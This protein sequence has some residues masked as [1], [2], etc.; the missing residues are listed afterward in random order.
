[1]PSPEL[2]DM[3]LAF[4][5]HLRDEGESEYRART[6]AVCYMRRKDADC[7]DAMP[8]YESLARGLAARCPLPP[9]IMKQTGETP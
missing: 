9:R 3:G 2:V 1:M 8:Y 4:Y 6:L 5:D 7:G